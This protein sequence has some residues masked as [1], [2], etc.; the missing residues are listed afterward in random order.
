MRDSKIMQLLD[1]T[2]HIG[3]LESILANQSGRHLPT[4]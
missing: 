1:E 3:L 4:E 2:H